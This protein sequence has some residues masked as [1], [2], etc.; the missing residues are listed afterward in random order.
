MIRRENEMGTNPEECVREMLDVIPM[1]MRSLRAEF[2]SH[3]AHDL[4]IPQ[5]RTLMYLR[6]SP[7]AALNDVAE[8]LGITPP[9]TSK[10]IDGLVARGLIDRRESAVDRRRI[11]LA[12][13]AAGAGLADAS[14]RETQ[15]AFV[16]RFSA[17]PEDTLEAIT[18][19]M[20]ALRPIFCDGGETVK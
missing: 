15:A 11:T 1:V 3:R 2:R 20:Q 4:N 5:F 7:G 6:R 17:L 12:L 14:Y 16:E 19:A 9:S 18:Q 10:L 8:H 13:T